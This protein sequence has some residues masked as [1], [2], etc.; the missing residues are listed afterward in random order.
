MTVF[1]KSL[2]LLKKIQSIAISKAD[3]KVF[4]FKDTVF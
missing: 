1:Y 2:F 3:L 4:G